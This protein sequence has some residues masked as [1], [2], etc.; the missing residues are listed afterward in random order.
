MGSPHRL[1]IFRPDG[2]QETEAVLSVY[3]PQANQSNTSETDEPI[4]KRAA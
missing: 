1:R 3:S 4:R 2:E